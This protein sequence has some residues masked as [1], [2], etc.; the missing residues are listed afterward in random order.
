MLK[1]FMGVF[2][3][4]TCL[5]A[6]GC[7]STIGD[8]T[9]LTSKNINLAN[10]S[11]TDELASSEVVVG[12]DSADIICIFPTGIPNLKEA[13]DRAIEKNDSR[14]L[15]NVRLKYSFFYI[16]YI[17]GQEKYTVEGNPSK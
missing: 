8:F 1:K 17:Y 5:F 14:L 6:M 16:P 13:V 3:V 11:A 4:L 7:T 10:F 12:E 2:L 9:L 15:T